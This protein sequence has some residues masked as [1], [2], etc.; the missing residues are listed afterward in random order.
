MKTIVIGVGNEYRGDDGAGRLVARRLV[1]RVPTDVEV[2][3]SSG[4]SAGLMEVW[5]SY[6]RVYLVD[7]VESH[8]PPGTIH[9]IEAHDC[10]MP[11][12]FFHCSTHAFSIAEA[13]ELARSLELLPPEVIVYGIEGKW[14]E[15]GKKL[16][17]EVEA[18]IATVTDRIIEELS[19]NK[20][21]TNA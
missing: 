2:R 4:E 10:E 20:G 7:A 9:R 16:T 5:E 3:E 12:D 1:N 18:G 19:P 11:R 13:I 14:F 6:N 8:Q 21:S 17:P 15:S